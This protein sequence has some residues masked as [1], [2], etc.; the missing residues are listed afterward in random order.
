MAVCV[1]RHP[2]HRHGDPG[3]HRAQRCTELTDRE[4]R[5]QP[6]GAGARRLLCHRRGRRGFCA[7]WPQLH[8]AR[9]RAL[10]PGDPAGWRTRWTASNSCPRNGSRNQP[11]PAPQPSRGKSATA[12]SGGSPIGAHEGEFHGPRASMGNICISTSLVAF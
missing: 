11:G 2:C 5:S 3:G 7:G 4:D 8:H 1:D 10:W 9:L 12:I 6:L